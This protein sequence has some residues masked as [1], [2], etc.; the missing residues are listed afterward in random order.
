MSK[1]DQVYMFNCDTA[2]LAAQLN[3]EGRELKD[4]LG[5]KGSNLC[6]MTSSGVPVPQGFIVTTDVCNEYVS[7][8]H[9]LPDGVDEAVY[10]AMAKLE[11]TTGKS[12]GDPA[13][14]LLVSVRSGSKFSMPGMMDTVLNLGM[15]DEVA[16]GMV[17]LFGDERFVYDAYRRLITMFGDVV[18][19][20]ERTNF[21]ACLDQ[22]KEAE[23]VTADTDV[24]AEG[25]KKVVELQKEVYR[26]EL[27][28]DFP[29]DG[30]AQLMAGVRAVFGS[31]DNPRA[32]SYRNINK[33][34]HDLGT[35]VNVQMMVFGNRGEDCGTGVAFTRDP[36]TG[37]KVIYGDYLVNAQGEDVV[38]GI[39]TPVPIATLADSM[40]EVYGQFAE[41]CEDLEDFYRNMQDVEFTV[42]EG[43]LWMLQT[44]DGKRTAI[45]AI[46]IATDMV[47]E[48]LI[49]ERRA[50]EI[51]DA[52]ALDQLLHPQFDAEK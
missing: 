20:V 2:A 10:A 30:R 11:E 8:G 50:I 48:G 7:L 17:R 12:F 34:P 35:A 16:E 6:L 39:R 46:K 44:R 41:I 23:G 47:A 40:P 49:D 43:K 21:D 32:T 52:Q 24:S 29:T 27:G 33:I 28:E 13:G 18:M 5:G 3:E 4:L 15:N 36:A 1:Y 19:G 51:M 26:A 22:V 14:P 45:A 42:E 38:A 37:E 25:L 9:K 31:W